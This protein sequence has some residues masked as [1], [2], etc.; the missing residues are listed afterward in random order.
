VSRTDKPGER[1]WDLIAPYWLPL[2]E[3][4]DR[5]IDSFLSRSQKV[6]PRVLH[7][8]AAHWCRS[9][10]DNGGFY[11][12]FYNT[13]GLLAPEAVTGFRAIG[14]L[15]WS[16]LLSEAMAYFG[17]PYPRDRSVRLKGLPE[18]EGRERKE[19]DPFAALDDRFYRCSDAT[20]MRWE[21]AADSYA[22]PAA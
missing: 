6:P 15:E 3:E 19:W 11:Q 9:E 8:Y 12:L 7:L 21:N 18:A 5:D 17:D 13:T 16:V 1:Y 14:L 4:W 20:G 2:N 10:V 22:A